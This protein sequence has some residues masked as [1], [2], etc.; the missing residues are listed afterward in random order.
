M[1]YTDLAGEDT[2]YLTPIREAENVPPGCHG[3]TMIPEL[4]PG[5]FSGKPGSFTGFTHE[6]SRAHFYRAGLEA[7][8]CYLA[9][10]LDMLQRVGNY[11]AR[12]IICVGGGSKNKLWNQIRADVLGIPVKAIDMKETTALGAALVAF[13]GIG[14][15]KS[16]EEAFTSFERG[17]EIYEPGK[18]HERYKE[19]HGLFMEKVFRRDFESQ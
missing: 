14:I 8:S 13:T 2:R 15:Y 11:T 9:Y 17:Y 12:E 18:D 16:I 3:V 19:V 10:G 5:S 7:L 6:T 4:Y 1:F